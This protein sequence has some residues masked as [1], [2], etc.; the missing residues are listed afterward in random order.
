M[1]KQLRR[2]IIRKIILINNTFNKINFYVSCYASCCPEGYF[3]LNALSSS[4]ESELLCMIHRTETSHLRG[5][6]IILYTWA[7]W[8]PE[9]EPRSLLVWWSWLASCSCP[10]ALSKIFGTCI[11]ILLI[12]HPAFSLF[13]SFNSLRTS[14]GGQKV[15][16][17]TIKI[18]LITQ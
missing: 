7:H 9:I 17:V 10:D 1:G 4:F 2:N 6:H 11:L 14:H 12:P 13:C 16:S 15:V 3:S 18:E 8:H 5:R